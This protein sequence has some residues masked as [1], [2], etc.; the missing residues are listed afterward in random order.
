MNKAFL[1]QM[2]KKVEKE[3]AEKEASVLEFWKEEIDR[4]LHKK[5][6]SLSAMQQEMQNLSLRMENRLKIL[7]RSSEF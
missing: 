2:Q 6:E 4:L 3:L 1:E 5:T 7:K